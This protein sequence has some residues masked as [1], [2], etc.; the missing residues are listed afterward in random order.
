MLTGVPVIEGVVALQVVWLRASTQRSSLHIPPLPK[1][2][3]LLVFL[4]LCLMFAG[5]RDGDWETY[6]PHIRDPFWT[7]WVRAEVHFTPLSESSEVQQ[8]L[9]LF[10][11]VFLV[12]YSPHSSCWNPLST[13]TSTLTLF[14][15]ASDNSQSSLPVTHYSQSSIL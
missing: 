7:A 3:I 14:G 4:V 6:W 10:S 9:S 8:R 1:Q 12:F 5:F 13:S 11:S 2:Q 15:E